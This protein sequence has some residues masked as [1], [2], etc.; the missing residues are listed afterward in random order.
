MFNWL[1]KQGV[2]STDG[3]IVQSVNRFTIEYKELGRVLP[4]SVERGLLENGKACIYIYTDEFEK[5]SD[6]TPISKDAQKKI[7]RNFTEAMEFQSVHVII[8]D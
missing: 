2:E 8:D 3:F 5:W 1:N 4:I 6:G 7:L